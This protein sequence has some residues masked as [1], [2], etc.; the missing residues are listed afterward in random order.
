MVEATKELGISISY[1]QASGDATGGYYCPHNQDPVTQTRSSAQ[2]AYYETA[3]GRSNLEVITGHRV[4]RIVTLTAS[5]SVSV[6]GL[7]VS[8]LYGSSYQ[9]VKL[10][11]A[12]IVGFFVQ[13]NPSLR[14]CQTRGHSC[15]RNHPH[16]PDSPS[17]GHRR[18]TISCRHWRRQRRRSTCGRTQLARPRFADHGQ[19]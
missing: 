9:P 19:L 16:S 13:L 18:P 12:T 8:V 7:E 17:F 1:D 3:R 14:F 5:G 6:T 10:I 2:E 11:G 15:R 4:T